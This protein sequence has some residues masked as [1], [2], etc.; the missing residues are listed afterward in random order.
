MGSEPDDLLQQELRDKSYCLM[1]M[2]WG[3]GFS[4]LAMIL[5]IVALV[6]AF[7]NNN[8][9][10]AILLQLLSFASAYQSGKLHREFDD[11][12]NKYRF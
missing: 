2:Q 4:I 3:I 1:L 12:M 5:T 11:I 10:A 7:G 9:G 8:W 6:E